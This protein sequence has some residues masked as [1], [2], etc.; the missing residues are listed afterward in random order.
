MLAIVS[1]TKGVPRSAIN[2]DL[3]IVTDMAASTWEGSY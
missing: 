2:D 1:H 3:G